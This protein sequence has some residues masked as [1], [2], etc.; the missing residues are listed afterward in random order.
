MNDTDAGAIPEQPRPTAQLL[1]KQFQAKFSTKRECFNFL[2]IDC[3]AYLPHY[4]TVTIYF[5][6][7]FFVLT[8]VLFVA[9]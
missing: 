8:D 4:S 9:P 7:C 5:V 2:T 1:A 6:S 3:K